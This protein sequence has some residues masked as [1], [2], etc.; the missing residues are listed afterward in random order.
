MTV[1]VVARSAP[2][3]SK[4]TDQKNNNKKPLASCIVCVYLH[5][6]FFLN[7]YF[8]QLYCPNGS[9]P[10]ENLDCFPQGKP[11][12]T[13]SCY[14]TYDA[15]VQAWCFSVSIIHQT[16]AW[17]TGSLTCV[18]MLMYANA[19]GGRTNNVRESALKA[20]CGKKSFTAPGN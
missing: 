3:K 17:T 15:P 9:S 1:I 7:F 14:P 13:E 12:V 20:D 18:Q 5:F 6:N 10:L 11:A 8:L 4:S 19:Q 16:L 2:S